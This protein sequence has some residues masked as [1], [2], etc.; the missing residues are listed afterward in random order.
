MQFATNERPRRQQ[1]FVLGALV[2]IVFSA[3]I[4]FAA[5]RSNP[6]G[7]FLDE[8]SIAYNA[9][10]LSS[11]GRDEHGESWPLYFR[12][13]GEFKN[14]VY[15]YL[16]AAVF[17]VTGPGILSARLLSA[18]AGLVTVLFLG[19]LALQITQ[20]RTTGFL[21][22]LLVLLT[23]WTFELSR[24]VLEVAIYPFMVALFLL[25][26]W[27]A[28]RKPGWSVANI[29]AIAGTLALL[30]YT[31]SIGR[32][33][34]PLLALGLIIFATRNRL[35]S[36]I[37][38]WLVF[39]IT[40]IPLLVFYKNHP[41]AL[42]GRFLFV[43]Y[44][45]PESSWLQVGRD[46]TSH[47]LANINP[48][49]LFV[50]ESAKTNE[51]LH[52]PGPPAMLTVTAV[53]VVASL[54]L[55][56]KQRRVNAWW[57]FI[58]YSLIA[59]LVPASLTTDDFHML[60]LAPLPAFLLVVTIPALQWLTE[61]NDRWRRIALI[62]TLLFVASQGLFFQWRYHASVSSPGRLH[63]FDADYPAKI[64]PSALSNAGSQPVYLAD[65]SARPAYVQA[66]WYAT[67]QGI[68][69]DKF[70]S[71]GFDKPAPQN[72]VVIT[73]EERCRRC[74]VLAESE[75]YKTYIALGE[76]HVPTRLP[77]DSMISEISVA[78]PPQ[79]LRAGQQATVQVAV[80]NLSRSAWVAGDRSG[81]AFRVAVG[82]HWLDLNGNS[83]VNDDGR[84]PIQD[85]VRPGE[86]TSLSLIINAP[87]RPGEYLL[88][89]DMVQEG[90]SWFGLKGSRTWR[91]R[92]VVDD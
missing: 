50:S 4:Q 62:V 43:S 89:V 6:P 91:G 16:L 26:V 37:L 27:H 11:S 18:T 85:D 15:I 55:L 80:K 22:G 78:D 63:T 39:A 41:G 38:T 53:L 25:A 36:I 10:T 13:F 9:H 21:V 88:E 82:N 67:L 40:W 74:R 28:A 70:I 20:S 23:P 14:P 68:P 31:Y 81:G 19:T 17:R 44:L 46:F 71:L 72:A 66:L 45:K 64:L 73:T 2:F 58:L 48:W 3:L 42:T 79:R 1:T 86:T 76:P 30:T 57:I 47:F 56:I 35:R 24:L 49:S 83:V 90:A 65:N 7:F 32:L 8:S 29:C 69:L 92:V 60:R 59:S 33:L 12:A 54:I 75:P 52:V 61:T 5:L 34:A 77:D 84:G 87:R 51:L